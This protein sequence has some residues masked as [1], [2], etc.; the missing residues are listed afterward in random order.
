MG[1]DNEV[2]REVVLALGAAA[3]GARAVA[4]SARL[5]RSAVRTALRLPVIGPAGRRGLDRLEAEGERVLALAPKVIDRGK[6]I[7]VAVVSA[8]IA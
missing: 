1:E 3:V 8:I 5:S 6:A 4:M 2:P 7:V